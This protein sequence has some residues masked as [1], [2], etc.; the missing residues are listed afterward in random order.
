MRELKLTWFEALP[1]VELHL[2]LEGAIPYEALWHLVQKYGG[3]VASLDVLKRRF[4]YKDFAHFLET[5]TWKNQFLR[6]YED[7]SLIAEAVAR[8]L[9]SQ[10]IHYAEVFFSPPDFLRQ[11][12]QT[13]RITEAVRRGLERVEE[14]EI[15]LVADLV[16]DLGPE[17]GE[18]TLAE[19]NE[20]RHL[21]VVG[22]GIGGSERDFPPEAFEGVFARARQLG[23]RT[24][25]HAGEGAG[26][27]SIW[28]AIRRL[29]V[30]RVGHGT[31]A[32]ED[33]VL[34]D[35][36]VEQGIPV[37]MC[38][39]SNVRTGVVKTYEEHP[40]RRYFERGVNLSINTDDP[41]MFG[42]SL[43]E[44]YKMLVEKKGFTAEEVKRLV[45]GAVEMSWMPEKRK[46]EMVEAFER[47]P[48]WSVGT[49][50]G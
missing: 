16:R 26:P 4:A 14:I 28:V 2:H 29:Q 33:E 31:R 49:S 24:S 35:Y 23:F 17:R 50:G 47:D 3:D 12:L 30:D 6:E 45:L 25:A 21:G 18:L 15:A 11:G 40:V 5:W 34:L 27:E 46:R 8:D 9:A 41:K 10:N 32:E 7:F 48:A 36:I 1:K 20:V 13:Q 37:E 39:I 42:N 43:A 38:P 19:V 22:V 44:E